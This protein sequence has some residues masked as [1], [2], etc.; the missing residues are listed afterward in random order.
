MLSSAGVTR[1]SWPPA[2][3]RALPQAFD[4]PIVR[5]NPAGILGKKARAERLLARASG[6]DFAVVRPVGLN[7]DWPRGRPVFSQGD[8]A[9][10]RSNRDDVAAVLAE[11]LDGDAVRG[12]TFEMLTLKGYD[13][14]ADGFEA[15]FARLSAAP[16]ATRERVAS[17]A[18]LQQ[19]LPGVAQDPT[20]LEMGRKYEEVDAGLVTRERNAPAT[21]REKAVAGRAVGQL[22]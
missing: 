21:E 17:Y 11:A 7:E 14:P 8:V 3:Q 9:V 5:L 22:D 4:I 10:G 18:L 19:L 12:K 16:L 1:P 6:G 2:L 20:K 13:A 15:A